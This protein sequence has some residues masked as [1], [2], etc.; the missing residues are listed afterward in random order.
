MRLPSEM[1]DGT[2]YIAKN[3][4]LAAGKIGTNHGLLAP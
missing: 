4:R 1:G 3:A 2:I